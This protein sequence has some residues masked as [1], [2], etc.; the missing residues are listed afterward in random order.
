MFINHKYILL[1]VFMHRSGRVFLPVVALAILVLFSASLALAQSGFG[2]ARPE[3]CGNG[4]CDGSENNLSCPKDCTGRGGFCGDRVCTSASENTT[5]CPEDCGKIEICGDTACIGTEDTYNCP[6]DCGLPPDCGNKVC[7]TREHAYNCVIDCGYAD[8]C[9]N[10]ICEPKENFYNCL[11]D[12]QRTQYRCGDGICDLREDSYNCAYDCGAPA[13]CGNAVCDLPRE[14]SAN[15]P[16]D[17][18]EFSTCGNKAC[19]SFENAYNCAR[20]C[21]PV[22]QGSS[23]ET[24]TLVQPALF[25]RKYTKNNVHDFFKLLVRGGERLIVSSTCQP[26]YWGPKHRSTPSVT[27]YDAK[28]DVLTRK[29]VGL[30][31][32]EDVKE[33]LVSWATNSSKTEQALVVEVGPAAEWQREFTCSTK[34]E[35][36]PVFDLE[37]RGDAS[38]AFEGAFEVVPGLY[39]E[40]WLLGGT[41]GADNGDFYKLKLRRGDKAEIKV[42]PSAGAEMTLQLYDAAFNPLAVKPF[43]ARDEVTVSYVATQGETIYFAV[44]RV[45]SGRYALS[46]GTLQ[47]D[48]CYYIKCEPT[49]QCVNGA[50]V[51]PDGSAAPAP[52]QPSGSQAFP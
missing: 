35:V 46:I 25:E 12:C 2:T 14:S 47:V 22:V 16:E 21:T 8:S 42:V 5:N 3:G 1:V 4:I 45:K 19:D 38:E 9:G 36:L 43:T 23:F 27:L 30:K 28:K 17:C 52:E 51:T 40:N 29:S 41:E 48:L 11:T 39:E 34:F 24:A 44:S 20:D 7:D 18:G 50:C 26:L 33:M 6:L 49:Q 13:S 10:G 15:C 31:E 32:K 37:D